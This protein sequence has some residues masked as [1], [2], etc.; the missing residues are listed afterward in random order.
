MYRELF[1][2]VLFDDDERVELLLLLE[3]LREEDLSELLDEEIVGMESLE[4]LLFT[5]L[6]LEENGQGNVGSSIC[7]SVIASADGAV[8][9][10]ELPMRSTA[11]TAS[12]ERVVFIA[13][14]GKKGDITPKAIRRHNVQNP[15]IVF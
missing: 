2:E 5:E 11:M 4:E 3:L 14:K 7:G 13:Q 1:E 10:S 12:E 8:G 15:R 9:T 6:L